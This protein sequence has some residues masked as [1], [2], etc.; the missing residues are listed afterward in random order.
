MSV[1]RWFAGWRRGLAAAGIIALLA[2]SLGVL[3]AQLRDHAPRAILQAATEIPLTALSLAL[4]WLVVN[5]LVLASY[6]LVA[7]RYVGARVSGP[8]AAA[9]SAAGFA[10]SQGLGF[11]VLTGGSVRLRLYTA[12]GLG[13]VDIARITGFNSFSFWSGSL[14]LFGAIFAFAPQD[15]AWA[16]GVAAGPLRMAGIVALAA[17]V[18]YVAWAGGR[19]FLRLGP[20]RVAP[21][22]R[23][24]ALE[25][26]GLSCAD[27]M[28]GAAILFVLLPGPVRP[29]FPVVLG[30]YVAAQS[31]A[32]ISRVPGGLGVF[33][34][35]FLGLIGGMSPPLP[36]VSGLLVY[37]AVHYLLPLAVAGIALAWWEAWR[38][39]HRLEAAADAVGD[40]AAA[41]TPLF[42]GGL[43]F[44]GGALL[45]VTGVLPRGWTLDLGEGLPLALRELA[46]LVASVVGML[47]LL[48]GWG[49]QRRSSGAH[50]LALVAVVVAALFAGLGGYPIWT[51]P[52]LLFLGTILWWA[53]KE[54]D[55][56]AALTAEPFSERWIVLVGSAVA[57]IIWVG[58]VASRTIES[59]LWW[60]DLMNPS[61]SRLAR[62][63]L[64][65]ALG[66]T[67]MTVVRL[68]GPS[69]QRPTP[70]DAAQMERAY[71]LALA[72]PEPNNGH[73]VLL[74]DKQLLFD[75]AGTCFVMYAVKGNSW[76]AYGDP[77]GDPESAEELAWHFRE[78]VS[79]HRGRLAFYHVGPTALATYVNM[80]MTLLKLGEEARVDLSK[81]SLEGPG[82]GA[83]R[84]RCRAEKD[85]ARFRVLQ[86]GEEVGAA[87]P[88]LRAISEE[89]MTTKDASE[90]GF[91]LGSFSESYIA[92]FPVGIIEVDGEIV[93]FTNI[94]PTLASRELSADLMR[95]GSQAP[96]G[97]MDYLFTRL[98]LW[99]R[100]AGYAW[101]SLGMAPLSGLDDRPD[102][103]A[104]NRIG[105]FVFRFGEHFYNFEGL[106]AF[107]EK[108]DPVW[109]PRYLACESAL[110]APRV[111]LDVAA[112]IGG[113]PS[114]PP[115]TPA[116]APDS[117]RDDGS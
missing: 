27:W 61:N 20:W 103:P 71:G 13:A 49:L 25:Q 65:M 112:L 40:A 62:V 114:G 98:M 104:W 106:R 55:R 74:G 86:A 107:K 73:L 44:V 95:Y 46:H 37:R 94:R 68:L 43:T 59:E 67:A 90:K 66:L 36:V 47:L 78:L 117:M 110:S 108:F 56:P 10:F 53:R 85:G 30:I 76:I 14:I 102:A 45:L 79:H 7:L 4:A 91:S 101:F 115:R 33:E 16:S 48:V 11:P 54:F 1:T 21:P 93:A 8:R 15:A 89:W 6:D 9:A 52:G 70:P 75:A 18:V 28:T 32:S 5:Y 87:L 50:R 80:G 105:A 42:L 69:R 35:V 58:L 96:K 23:R 111:L 31:A 39:R 19:R 64:G 2:V 99:G 109:V 60:R 100:E 77:I 84:K 34:A 63:S 51:V 29:D 72:S 22:T 24:L 116:G 41:V 81:V 88:R 82:S 38:R 92:H 3:R 83:W 113:A 26:L 12:W 17:V 97:T 57:S